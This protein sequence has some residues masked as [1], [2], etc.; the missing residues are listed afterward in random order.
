M[1][2][3]SPMDSSFL[4]VETPSAHMHVGWVST[5]ELPDRAERLDTALLIERLS[6]RLH[7]FPR[8][9]QR[10]VRVPLG[11]AEPVWRDDPGF[12]IAEHV[13]EAPP[14]LTVGEVVDGVLSRPLD[15]GRPLWEIVVVPRSA[16]GQAA[17]VGKVHHAMVDGIAAVELGVLLFD[18]APDPPGMD[19]PAWSP[20]EADGPIRLAADAV[21][22]TALQQFRAA[23]R[24]VALGRTPARTVRVADTMRRAAMSLADDALR[25]APSSPFNVPI[26]P[27]RTLVGHA[28]GLDR[29]LELK[30]ALGTT[31]NDVVLAV[32]AGALRGFAQSQGVP[33]SDLRVMVPVSVRDDSGG[34]PGNQITFAFVNLP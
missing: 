20:A 24:L 25:P 2:R 29:L 22:D 7:L 17:I 30:T 13:H 15:R 3:L 4:R 6:S 32:C 28:I 8:F 9:R 33:A 26:G 16:P 19:P 34:G 14:D 11:M 23:G 27:R 31:L 12:E 18:A 1:T 5:L 10:V 21:A